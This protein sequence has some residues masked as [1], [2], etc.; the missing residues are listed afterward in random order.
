MFKKVIKELN[1]KNI[2]GNYIKTLKELYYYI[3]VYANI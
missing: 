1:A 2:K 3:S